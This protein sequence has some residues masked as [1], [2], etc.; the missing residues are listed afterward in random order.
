MKR[1]KLAWP[2][3]F[4]AGSR[5]VFGVSVAIGEHQAR[6]VYGE[7]SVGDCLRFKTIQ[8]HGGIPVSSVA[9]P[10][11]QLI[12][13]DLLANL[14]QQ[15]L[16]ALPGQ[17][18]KPELLVICLPSRQAYFGELVV[19]ESEDE[20]SIEF[21]IQDMMEAAAGNTEREAA[22]DWQLKSRL[23]D[24]SLTL[25]VAGID[26]LQV[27]EVLA[28]CEQ[29]KLKCAGITLDSVASINGYVQMIRD[30]AALSSLR[31]L[32]HGELSRHRIRLA[33]FSQGVLF[34]ESTEQSEEGFSLVQSVAAL[35][36]LVA[37]WAREGAMEEPGSVR[38]ILGGEIM[39]AKGCDATVRRSQILSS[40][41]LDVTPRKELAGQWHDSVVPYG[42]LEAMPCA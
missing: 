15:V 12:S 4:R 25:A 5:S 6:W 19:S 13:R 31:F 39:Y 17:L 36:R 20:Q 37:T 18:P 34:H 26:Q 11:G 41:L 3:W 42:A 8:G 24:G 22:Y 16:F 30:D 7:V 29:V 28:A 2:D 21:Q 10:Q 35:E 9:E 33:V 32:L 14:F 38:L 23:S 27:D 40:R 1:L